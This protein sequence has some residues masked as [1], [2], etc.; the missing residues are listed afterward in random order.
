MKTFFAKFVGSC[1]GLGF[2]PF[3]P[4]TVTSVVA[5]V[6][7]AA[8]PAF[9]QLEIAVSAVGV[10][11]VVG[12]WSA[13]VMEEIYGRDPSQVTI[14]EVA[15]Q[16][17]ALLLLPVGWLPVVMGFAAFRFFD[18]LKPEPVNFA[19]KLPGGWGVMVDDLL[20]GVY[21]NLSVRTVL[22]LLSFFPATAPL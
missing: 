18:I 20:A 8:V 7:F 16:W 9:Q 12:L 22:W 21:A 1:A 3:A 15:G 19:Q 13:G 11:F 4:G 5:A 14:D 6:F 17:I 2:F 10:V